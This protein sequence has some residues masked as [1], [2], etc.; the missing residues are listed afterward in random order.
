MRLVQNPKAHVI[1]PPINDRHERKN[2]VVQSAGNDG[3]EDI[4]AGQLGKKYRR[5]GFESNDWHK[6][7]KDANGDT[8]RN[9]FGRVANRQKLQRMLMKP[10]ARILL[11]LEQAH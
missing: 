2:H 8:A 5:Y 3:R 4:A 1:F 11:Y 6:A 10:L 9:G 7:K